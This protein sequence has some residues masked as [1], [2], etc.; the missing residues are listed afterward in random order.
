M[1]SHCDSNPAQY[2]RNRRFGHLVHAL[3]RAAGGA[4][5]P[6]VGLCLNASKAV[7]SL[8]KG[9][10]DISRS[11]VSRKAQNNVTLLGGRSSDRS[12]HE[13]DDLGTW[14][15]VVLGRAVTTLRSVETQPS[16]WGFVLSVRRDPTRARAR[17]RLA[18][19]GSR[20][21]APSK[22]KSNTRL[23]DLATPPADSSESSRKQHEARGLC[24]PAGRQ[25]RELEKATRGSG[26]LPLRRPTAQ[27]AR[28]SNTRLGDFATPPADSSES[29]RK[30]HEA[31]GLCHSA[32]R[33]LRE[34]EKATR[35]SGTL[36][37]R[38]PTAQRAR[39]SNTRLGDFATPP[40]DSSESSRKQHEARGLCH[41]AGRQLRELE[42]A[43][44]G[45]GTLPLRRPTAQRAR[46]SNTRLGDFATP[47]AD[48]S[49]SSRKQ[50]EARGLCHS[51]GR[52]LRELEKATRGSGTLPLRR[53]TAQRA[54]ESNTRLGDFATPPAD[55]SE[56]SR[57]QHE[58]R[59]LCHSAGRQ[60]REL[61][62]A[63]RGSGTLPLR[64][65]TA[66][67]ARES[68]T[69]LGDFATPPA[70]SSESSRKQHE[71]RGL[72]HPAGRQLRE[73][74]KA[75]RGS[76][77]LPLR[78]PTAQ[79][80]RESNTRLGTLPLRRPTAQRARESNTRLGDFATPPADSSEKATRGSGLCHP[81]ADS[82][83]SS[84]KQHEARDFATRRPTAQRARESNT[85]LGTLPLA[86]RQL[87]ELEKA[88]RGSG[89]LPPAGRQLRELEKATRGSG[90]LPLRRP[91]AQRARESNTRLGDFATPPADS[92]ESSRKQ[93]EARDFA[94]PPADSSESS[95]HEARRRPTA[96]R[97]RESNTRLG[98]FAT[99]PADSSESSRKQ[100]EARGLC[101]SA[102]RQL[103]EL[104][105][106]TRGSGTLPL[107]RPTAQRARES[108]TRLGDFATPPADSSESSRKQHEARGLC[109]SVGLQFRELEKATRG[110]GTLPLR[111]PTA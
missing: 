105:K 6:S 98:D 86:G 96:Q 67:R 42:K 56:S 16:A 54:R 72:C 21:G 82:S 85:R 27:R 43:T 70:D 71:A 89:T 64:R 3:G 36:P 7:S 11:L 63:T 73:L 4:K 108:N 88:T 15:G 44:R 25:L 92:S 104:E 111:R 8:V 24:H 49:E 45:S 106:A 14:R 50:H 57:K 78:R 97:A 60:L 33:Q 41:S 83:E 5:L 62:K 39:E 99:P 55:S 22:R 34:L 20:D 35:G 66:Q 75:T 18:R 80:A 40:A 12:S 95:Q 37:L 87:R 65:P 100:H 26:T 76:G 17:L 110:S 51:A 109:H 9:G 30:Q 58:A 90:T 13:P 68:N 107:R 23:G 91:T 28:E 32:G 53:P 59:G 2:E 103:R 29:S 38:R 19:G 74:E 61:E 81:P 84:R 93:H 77:T 101:H 79:R 1:T 52:Q 94:T 102:G 31:R 10:N 48:S 69:R 47:P 46:E